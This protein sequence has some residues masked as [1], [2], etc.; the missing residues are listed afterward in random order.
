V[1]AYIRD[2]LVSNLKREPL[3]HECSDIASAN[4]PE[5]SVIFVIGDGFPRFERQRDCRYVF[6]NF[7]LLFKLRWWR[8]I[9]RS[10]HDWIHAKRRAFAAKS[11]LYDMVLDFNPRQARLL[12][13]NGAA[14]GLPVRYFMTG[15]A[16][17]ATGTRSGTPSNAF[18][19]DICFTGTESPRRARIRSQLESRGISV[20]PYLAS[21]LDEVI[22]YCQLV[23]NVHSTACDTLEAPRI[24]HALSAGACLLTE[25]SYGLNDIVPNDCYVSAP[26]RHLTRRVEE[27]L[28]NP[29]RRASLGSSAAS[30]M[31]TSYAARATECWRLIIKETMEL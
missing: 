6:V 18:T 9:P 23:L 30:Y 15:V 21:S 24:I 5:G 2:Q 17:A 25:V 11:D 4:L 22:P 8:P 3:C 28:C 12:Q 29:A 20:S 14:R 1:A 19:W 13:R 31:R 16:S 10:A 26:Y 27:L 7:S